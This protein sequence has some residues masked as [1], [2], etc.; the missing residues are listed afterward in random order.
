MLSWFAK[1]AKGMNS[2]GKLLKI[3]PQDSETRPRQSNYMGSNCQLE[4]I[5]I[6]NF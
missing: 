4:L 2:N 1:Y 3:N 6:S 5:K